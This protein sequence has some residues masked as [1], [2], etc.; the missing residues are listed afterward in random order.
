M[1]RMIQEKNSMIRNFE[2]VQNCANKRKILLL[3]AVKIQQTIQYKTRIRPDLKFNDQYWIVSK[4]Q[5]VLQPN[6][7]KKIKKRAFIR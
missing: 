5:A 6:S 2:I 1:R 3:K 4:P 7:E